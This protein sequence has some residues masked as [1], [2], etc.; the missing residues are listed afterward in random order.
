MENHKTPN[1]YS[2]IGMI[3]NDILVCQCDVKPMV[4]GVW[5]GDNPLHHATSI[6][7]FQI[8]IMYVAGRITYF[9][10]RPCHQTLI[11]SQLVVSFSTEKDVLKYVHIYTF[12]MS[13]NIF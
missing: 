11:I 12:T 6:L 7:L 3:G 13:H 9:L 10:L 4:R 1:L 2:S 5:F 8:I